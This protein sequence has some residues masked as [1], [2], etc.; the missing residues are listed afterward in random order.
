[1]KD[2]SRPIIIFTFWWL[3]WL[4]I[5]N[6]ELSPVYKASLVTQFYFILM[7]T[8]VF[9][10]Y[11][12]IQIYSKNIK[13]IY[14]FQYNLNIQGKI[15]F[16]VTLLVLSLILLYTGYQSGAFKL[17]I[18]EYFIQIRGKEG[19][20]ST[21]SNNK[22]IDIAIVYILVPFL[23]TSIILSLVLEK[24][25]FTVYLKYLIFALVISFT[26]I[27]QTSYL[28]SFYI[29]INVMYIV[30]FG[31]NFY[32]NLTKKSKQKLRYFVLI[33]LIVLFGMGSFRYGEFAILEIIQKYLITYYTLGF[34]FFDYQLNHNLYIQDL[35]YGKSFLGWFDSM[36]DL[37]LR[38]LDKDF[39]RAINLQNLEFNSF[40]IE[41]GMNNGILL[42]YNAF[43]TILFTMFKDFSFAGIFIY[44][45][46]Y[47]I[48]LSYSYLY[49]YKSEYRMLFILLSYSGLM[50]IQMSQVERP[51]FWFS[52]LFIFIIKKAF[53]NTTINKNF[54][55][56]G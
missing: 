56:R 46:M 20:G 35:S 53:I 43:S 18:L 42:K 21:L 27:Y 51:Y 47:G 30:F 48:A 22:Y 36:L 23:Y 15:F 54:K 39:Y 5:H 10:S 17:T 7:I 41:A 24:N 49:S 44:S 28:I 40:P 52:I 19:L 3:F 12:I 55:I 8:L 6:S 16:T 31:R 14:S 1:M 13:K 4:I 50:S 29:I 38:F 25:K 37:L 11:T 34:Y 9:I 45:S 33:I 2:K 26:Y 32:G